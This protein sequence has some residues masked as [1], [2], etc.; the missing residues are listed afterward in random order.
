MP[1][2]WKIFITVILLKISYLIMNQLYV[3]HLLILPISSLSFPG[4]IPW[5]VQVLQIMLYLQ[6]YGKMSL[7]TLVQSHIYNLNRLGSFETNH[8]CMNIIISPKC[9]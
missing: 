8:K 2:H 5:G 9:I 4:H 3:N 7:A 1:L 6:K